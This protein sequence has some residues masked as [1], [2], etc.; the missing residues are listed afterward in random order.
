LT[1]ESYK[2]NFGQFVGLL[3]REISPSQ[4]RYLHT[5]QHNKKNANTHLW[6]ERDSNPQSQCSSCWKPYVP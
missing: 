3:G 6:L 4:S 2:S 5:G 1:S